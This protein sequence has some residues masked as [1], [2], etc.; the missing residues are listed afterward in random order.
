MRCVNIIC[1]YLSM[2]PVTKLFEK[3]C[4][5]SRSYTSI[6]S[7]KYTRKVTRVYD[8]AFYSA[9]MYDIANDSARMYD[10]AIASARVYGIA[11]DCARVYD[12]AFH[13]ARVWYL[14]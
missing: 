5:I 12:I 4:L 7:Q 2:F 1:I 9:R 6:K 8:I 13:S 3:I 10:I 14:I 11:N